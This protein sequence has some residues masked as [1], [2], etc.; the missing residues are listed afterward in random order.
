MTKKIVGCFDLD[1]TLRSASHY[2][3]DYV[4]LQLGLFLCEKYPQLPY[5]PLWFP[6]FLKNLNE[7]DKKKFNEINHLTQKPYQSDKSRFPTSILETVKFLFKERNIDLSI[8]DENEI[9]KIANLYW[10]DRLYKKFGLDEGVWE[11]IEKL[12]KMIDYLILLTKGDFEV[13][14]KKIKTWDL[15]SIFDKCLIVEEKTPTIYHSLRQ[16]YEADIYFMAGDSPK[17]DIYAALEGGFNYAFYLPKELWNESSIK[18]L[19]DS[20]IIPLKSLNDLPD[21]LEKII[22]EKK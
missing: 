15:E 14:N 13:Q 2:D 1:G 7:R 18:N 5:L 22:T 20:R 4:L 8:E 9:I 11:T 6:D 10:D 19:N 16:Q 17:E 3:Y 21:V 12:K